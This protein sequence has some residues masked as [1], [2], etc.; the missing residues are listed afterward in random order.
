MNVV[1]DST[2]LI[3]MISDGEPVLPP[4]GKLYKLDISPEEFTNIFTKPNG[5]VKYD[6]TTFT[7]LPL[8]P[9]PAPV[10]TCTPW[11][12]VTELRARNIKEDVDI[13]VAAS[14]IV[15]QDAYRYATS[16]DSNNPLLLQ[17]AALLPTPLT[18][19]QVY[20]MIVSASQRKVGF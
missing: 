8:P 10:A 6:G 13:L 18:P 11:Q 5:G 9:P 2:D 12:F 7:V 4:G 16:F 19:D 3:I 20:Q 17:L 1:T 15:A 14:S